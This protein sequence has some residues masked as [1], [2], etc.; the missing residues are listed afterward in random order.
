MCVCRYMCLGAYRVVVVVVVVNVFVFVD[1]V[2]VLFAVVV[3]VVV[4]VVAVTV[5]VTVAVV[6]TVLVFLL[7]DTSVRSQVTDLKERV[8]PFFTF[9]AAHTTVAIHDVPSYHCRSP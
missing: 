2:A 6:A 3:A 7:S 4:V 9:V 5:A 1:V 8:P